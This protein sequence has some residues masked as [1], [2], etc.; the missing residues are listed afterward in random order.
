MCASLSACL[1]AENFFE[2]GVP[3]IKGSV[4]TDPLLFLAVFGARSLPA[5]QCMRSTP[6][7]SREVSSQSKDQDFIVE[8]LDTGFFFSGSGGAAAAVVVVGGGGSQSRG[9]GSGCRRW[10]DKTSY[11]KNVKGSGEPKNMAAL[12][13]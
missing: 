10:G 1:R 7:A 3:M 6:F 4:L 12:T 2:L 8:T 9:Q 5:V 11:L 13:L